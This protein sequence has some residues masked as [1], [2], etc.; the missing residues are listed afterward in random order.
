[1]GNVRLAPERHE[2][3]AGHVEGGHARGDPADSPEQLVA[4][5]PAKVC[6]RISSLLKKPAKGGNAGDRRVAITI[7]QQVTGILRAQCAHL[8]HVLLAAH[9]VDHTAG[10]E[11]EQGLEESVRHQVEDASR[12]CADAAGQKH[13]TQLADG[14]IGQH[15][16]DVVLHQADGGR[17]DGRRRADACHQRQRRGRKREKRVRARHHVNARRHHGRGVDQ[18]AD[19]RG[20]FHGVRQPDV[21]RNL[22]G[23]SRGAD[24]EQNADGGNHAAAHWKVAAARS[25]R[26]GTKVQRP[27]R[28]H[29]DHHAQQERRVTNA[30]DD[31]GF[32]SRVR[33]GLA[34]EVKTDQKVGAEPHAFPAH[35]H[36][37]VVVRQNQHQHGEHE[38]VQVAEEAVVPAFVRHVSGGVDVDQEADARDD[39]HH[40]AGERVELHPHVDVEIRQRP[41][42]QMECPGRK[43]RV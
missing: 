27:E 19:R 29:H 30:I 14:G 41:V 38:E 15:A 10:A 1:M 26:D 3:Q 36:H 23:L 8:A 16:L 34:L 33:G 28:H 20:A 6:H 7:V 11:E 17:P 31:E 35:E 39:Q 9:G 32:L 5:G 25:F 37:Q 22:R 12:E 13:V 18:G 42:R 43:P 40:H 4:V 24:E 21:E 2:D